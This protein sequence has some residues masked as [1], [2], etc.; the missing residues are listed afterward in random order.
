MSGRRVASEFQAEWRERELLRYSWCASAE[1]CLSQVVP[2]GNGVAETLVM[3]G[4]IERRC[5]G[6]W[7]H[8]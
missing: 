1:L 4:Y 7:L 8:V 2:V 6:T 5:H 3:H